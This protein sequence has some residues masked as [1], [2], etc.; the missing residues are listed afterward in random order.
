MRQGLSNEKR[1]KSA[2]RH[3]L[4]GIRKE[5]R[6]SILPEPPVIKDNEKVLTIGLPN[7]LHMAQDLDF[8]QIFFK[9]L[10]LQVVTSRKCTTPVKIG[11]QIAGAEFCA[12]F[13]G[14]HGH[15]QFLEDRCDYIF[16]PFYFEDKTSEKGYRRH[17]CYY[18]QFAPAIISRLNKTGKNIISQVK[19]LY[20]SFYT[21][22]SY[23][24]H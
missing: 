18:T 24:T 20:T 6:N 2:D 23:M 4:L 21:K 17:H 19:Y 8:W 3:D 12:P 15:V 1:V 10:G 16:L 11:K 22:S 13:L 7:A 14:L 9:E 5:V